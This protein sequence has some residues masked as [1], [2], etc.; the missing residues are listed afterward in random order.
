MRWLHCCRCILSMVQ[1]GALSLNG[2]SANNA[3]SGASL[4]TLC[5]GCHPHTGHSLEGHLPQCH[6]LSNRLYLLQCQKNPNQPVQH[7]ERC[8]KGSQDAA[9]VMLVHLHPNHPHRNR[10]RSREHQ[11]GRR[12]NVS[13]SSSVSRVHSIDFYTL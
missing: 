2:A 7:G 4:L 13:L 8:N 1:A 3:L 10:W 9:D 12:G 6:P 5:T 11:A